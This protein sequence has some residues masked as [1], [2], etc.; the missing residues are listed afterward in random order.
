[1]KRNI[2]MQL[3]KDEFIQKLEERKNKIK[4]IKEEKKER[5]K[6][7]ESQLAEESSTI[8]LEQEDLI[9][10]NFINKIPVPLS[11]Y[12]K[13]KEMK[14]KKR[15]ALEKKKKKLLSIPDHF[16]FEVYGTHPTRAGI[17]NRDTS[18]FYE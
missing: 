16:L 17:H 10:S 4:K 11:I 7:N 9:R 8:L 14:Q 13:V 5:Q 12:P 15:K 2:E 1:M 6:K 18:L 3:R